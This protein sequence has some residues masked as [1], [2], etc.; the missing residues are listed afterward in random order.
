MTRPSGPDAAT[1]G[2]RAFLAGA[3]VAGGALLAT[4]PGPR[5]RPAAAQVDADRSFLAFAAGVELV[6][7]AAYEAVLELLP[8]DLVPV[9]EVH[10]GHHRE[11][12]EALAELAGGE[13][14]DE[15]DPAILAALAPAIEE[16]TGAGSSLRFAKDLE[17]RILATYVAAVATLQSADAIVLASSIVPVEAAHAVV[18]AD[19]VEASLDETFPTGAFGPADPALGFSATVPPGP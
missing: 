15:A 14:P 3:A 5:G 2:R 16:L 18:L 9:A 17:E 10:L 8:E 19:L 1:S 11:H 6:L 4:G 7:V 12:A 13:A